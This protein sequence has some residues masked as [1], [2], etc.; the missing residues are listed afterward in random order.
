MPT[1]KPRHT[2]TETPEVKQA[3]DEVRAKLPEG[4]K[5]DYSELLRLGA[6]VK[7]R[8][9]DAQSKADRLALDRLIEMVRTRSI[10]VDLKAAEEV[11]RSGWTPHVD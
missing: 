4:E 3:L 5:I 11:R 8:R 1:T 7:A 6:E 9:L 2:I 10:P